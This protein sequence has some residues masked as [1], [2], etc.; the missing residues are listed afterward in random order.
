ML[1]HALQAALDYDGSDSEGPELIPLA[2]LLGNLKHDLSAM[3]LRM[4]TIRDYIP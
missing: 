2:Q 4:H 3:S 1:I